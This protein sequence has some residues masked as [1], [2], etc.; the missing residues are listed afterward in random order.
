LNE[1][2][3]SLLNEVFFP[4]VKEKKPE[5]SVEEMSQSLLNEVFFP[6]PTLGGIKIEGTSQSLLNEVFFPTIRM[7][8][9]VEKIIEV[10]IPSK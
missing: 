7:K 10:A 8:T 1:E 2:S 3:Q 5:I 6:T 4:T 9:I